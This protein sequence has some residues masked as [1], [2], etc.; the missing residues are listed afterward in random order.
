MKLVMSLL[1]S[2]FLAVGCGTL[3][4]K[5]DPAVKA[6]KNAPG[7]LDIQATNAE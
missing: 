4:D 1:A 5:V 3:A 2:L 6:G 7:T